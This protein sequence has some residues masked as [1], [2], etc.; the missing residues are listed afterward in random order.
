MG[1]KTYI[2]WHGDTLDQ[3]LENEWK[4]IAEELTKLM[5]KEIVSGTKDARNW[6]LVHFSHLTEGEPA[7]GHKEVS[8]SSDEGDEDSDMETKVSTTSSVIYK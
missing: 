7:H 3:V 4:Y 5:P 1:R 6:I 2:V 8:W